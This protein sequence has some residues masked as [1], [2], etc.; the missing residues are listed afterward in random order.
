MMLK[1][2]ALQPFSGKMKEIDVFKTACYMYI[3]GCADKFPNEESK[4]IWIL[5]YLQGSIAQ[6]WCE[7]AV[8][9][10]MNRAIPFETGDEL[11]EA[12]VKTFSDLN[13]ENTRVFEITTMNHGD[14]TADKHVQD[15]K[16][17]AHS[18]RYTGIMLMHEFKHSLNKAL[19]ERLNNLE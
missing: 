12:I 6:K 7:V 16:I 5:L 15:F 14:K 18:A 3:Q 10:I 8:R 13:E 4:I 1:I 19:Q 2:V 17:T 11:I 9:E